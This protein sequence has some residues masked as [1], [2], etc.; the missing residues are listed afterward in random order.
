MHALQPRRHVAY[1]GDRAVNPFNDMSDE[2]L[3]QYEESL[4]DR[5]VEGEDVWHDR[6]QVL[7]ELSRRSEARPS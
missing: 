6:D 5:E 3:V 7:W 2:E 1:A 4:Y